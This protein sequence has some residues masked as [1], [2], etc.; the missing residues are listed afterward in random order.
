MDDGA[1]S[2]IQ[3]FVQPRKKEDTNKKEDKCLDPFF[4]FFA[5]SAYYYNL[6][7]NASVHTLLSFVQTLQ[8]PAKLPL[9]PFH[10]V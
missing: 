4:F 3:N 5:L 8:F 1:N 7:S 10:P 2:S 9:P 6:W